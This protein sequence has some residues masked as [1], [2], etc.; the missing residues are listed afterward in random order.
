MHSDAR[1]TGMIPDGGTK[2]PHAVRCGQEKKKNSSFVSTETFSTFIGEGEVRRTRK[3]PH[4]FPGHLDILGR[5]AC[6]AKS[7]QPCPTLSDLMDC[8]PPDSS[9]HGILQARLLEWVAMPSSRGSS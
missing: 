9:V 7:L 6:G 3:C 8:N 2:I 1:D 4:P 5:R